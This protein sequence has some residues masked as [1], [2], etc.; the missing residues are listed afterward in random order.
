[1]FRQIP[2][3]SLRFMALSLSP[4]PLSGQE[5]EEPVA[6]SCHQD[7]MW[8]RRNLWSAIFEI[9]TYGRCLL[10]MVYMILYFKLF[11]LSIYVVN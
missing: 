5:V 3:K 2:Y 6:V 8:S 11:Y 4:S 1:M 10:G 7:E 9:D